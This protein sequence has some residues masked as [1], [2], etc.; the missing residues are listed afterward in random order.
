MTS[1]GKTLRATE[2]VAYVF[3]DL[4]EQQFPDQ[5]FSLVLLPFH[6]KSAI[7]YY[8]IHMDASV[9][10][11]HVRNFIDDYLSR[12]LSRKNPSLPEAPSP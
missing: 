8:E 12:L 3:R 10:P 4:L 7:F 5:T 1:T 9:C 6:E 11:E 2:Q